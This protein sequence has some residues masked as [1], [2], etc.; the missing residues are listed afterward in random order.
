MV[1]LPDSWSVEEKISHLQRRILVYSYQYYEIGDTVVD[2][3]FYDSCVKQLLMFKDEYPEE[4]KRSF[5]YYAYK[6]FTGETGFYLYYRLR[7]AHAK[8]IKAIAYSSTDSYNRA[9]NIK[10][11]N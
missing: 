7:T 3:P 10:S 4:Y 11:V 2:D 5:Y 8:I 1:K 6:D 9:N